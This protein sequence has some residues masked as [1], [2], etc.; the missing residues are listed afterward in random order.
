MQAELIKRA[1]RW[2]LTHRHQNDCE[3]P[4]FHGLTCTAAN[5]TRS[6]GHRAPTTQRKREADEARRRPDPC[7]DGCGAI[8]TASVVDV[9]ALVT[10][11][12]RCRGTELERTLDVAVLV[13]VAGAVTSADGACAGAL[14]T[15]P[16]RRGTEL[17]R[18]REAG[19]IFDASD[20]VPRGALV[21]VAARAG[22]RDKRGDCPSV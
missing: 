9:G 13:V 14:V 8:D 16:A 22:A 12:A 6:L 20:G 19:T 15:D 18:T 7:A 5:P 11:P 3:S 17:V 1:L 2:C 10:D 4:E 21:G